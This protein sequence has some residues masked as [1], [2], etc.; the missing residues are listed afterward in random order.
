MEATVK[1]TQEENV[2]Q[3]SENA[4]LFKVTFKHH[5]Q[6][7]Y[8]IVDHY[9]MQ[10]QFFA[11]SNIFDS[12]L[13][14]GGY[15]LITFEELE[16]GSEERIGKSWDE[17]IGLANDNFVDKAIFDCIACNDMSDQVFHHADVY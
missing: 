13:W 14:N 17:F 16:D 1:A 11:H 7:Y 3:V 2:N 5:G 12:P 4:K 8:I 10:D 9:M 15:E 6:K